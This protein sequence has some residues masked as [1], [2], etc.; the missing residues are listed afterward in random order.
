VIRRR[1][2]AVYRVIDEEELLSGELLP[3]DGVELSPEW[4]ARLSPAPRIVRLRNVRRLAPRMVALAVAIAA[5]GLVAARWA[6]PVARMP[7]PPHASAPL[8]RRA[9]PAHAAVAVATAPPRAP[10][11]D[12]I[13]SG[14]GLRSSGRSRASAAARPEV[15]LRAAARSRR[16]RRAG[17][18]G[19]GRSRAG[20]RDLGHPPFRRAGRL[21]AAPAQ[22]AAAAPRQPAVA[23]PAAG[24]QATLAAPS[25][26]APRSSAP[27]PRSIARGASP[28]GEFGF[29]R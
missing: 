15:R 25:A 21:A 4:A 17:L 6:L 23:G 5:L 27:A 20:R 3:A 7:I 28:A 9:R 22:P 10:A 26:P 29:E 2:L 24:P 12:R 18:A 11:T 1:P 19:A 13:G 8:L 14:D 16:L